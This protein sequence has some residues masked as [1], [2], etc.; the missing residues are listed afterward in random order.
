MVSDKNVGESDKNSRD[1]ANGSFGMNVNG[2]NEI[3]GDV[4]ME[5]EAENVNGEGTVRCNQGIESEMNNTVST[6]ILDTHNNNDSGDNGV[7][8]V[9]SSSADIASSSNVNNVSYANMVKKDEINKYLNF[10]PTVIADNGNEV[11]V[12]DELLVSKGSER[13]QLT[14]CGQFVGFNMHISELRYNIRRMWGQIW[15][16]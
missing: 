16:I 1:E 6:P 8:D 4:I 14:I 13:W 9:N 12:F 2:N 10:I 15:C 5:K 7:T 11:V 3:A